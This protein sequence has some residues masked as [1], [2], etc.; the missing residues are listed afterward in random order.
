MGDPP[1]LLRRTFQ[2]QGV[3]HILLQEVHPEMRK[4]FFV[5]FAY[6]ELCTMKEVLAP[7]IIPP[8]KTWPPGAMQLGGD[9]PPLTASDEGDLLAFKLLLRVCVGEMALVGYKDGLPVEVLP[10]PD[11]YAV[12]DLGLGMFGGPRSSLLNRSS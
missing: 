12:G 5:E 3:L 7:P 1:E 10:A 9:N 6:V 11:V 2:K 8:P 4:F